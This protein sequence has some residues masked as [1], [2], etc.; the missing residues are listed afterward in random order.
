[1][2]QALTPLVY[3]RPTPIGQTCRDVSVCFPFISLT[4]NFSRYVY[5]KSLRPHTSITQRPKTVS[6]QN[7]SFIFYFPTSHTED[8]QTNC[9]HMTLSLAICTVTVLTD[10]A[11][12][13]RLNLPK[14]LDQ[15]NF[16]TSTPLRPFFF[17][18][19]KPN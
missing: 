8:R 7:L 2:L 16:T 17:A 9:L 12:L 5:Q 14:H 15:N 19:R 10:S 13:C 1:M 3:S 18:I 11:T 4:T 6:A